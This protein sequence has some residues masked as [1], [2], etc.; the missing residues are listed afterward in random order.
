MSLG[1][2]RRR[3]ML[4][5]FKDVRKWLALFLGTAEG[6]GNRSSNRDHQGGIKN[7]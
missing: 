3:K 7:S 2:R 4:E 6:H 1:W 5:K